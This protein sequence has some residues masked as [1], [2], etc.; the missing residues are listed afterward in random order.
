MAYGPLQRAFLL[1]G[2]ALRSLRQKSDLPKNTKAFVNDALRNK[3]E[4][5]ESGF[6]EALRGR[7]SSDRSKISYTDPGTGKVVSRSV[8]QIYSGSAKNSRQAELIF[9][10]VK[11]LQPSHCVELGTS[12]G[13]SAL[14][15]SLAT[16]GRISTF[17]GASE[18]AQLA[19]K[20][21]KSA[22]KSNIELH[23]G[24]FS[25]TLPKFLEQNKDID[26][27]FI[28]GNHYYEPT[29]K[30]FN[31]FLESGNEGVTML[32]DDINWSVEM[33][34]AWEEIKQDNRVKLSLDMFHMG[35][36]FTDSRFGE[37]H[38]SITA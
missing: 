15:M 13:L 19:K 7:L 2:H 22:L 33:R 16:K 12:L 5:I 24:M 28:D 36:I 31:K 20:H 30:Y 17:E 23:T 1:V 34:K 9:R 4:R 37:G 18:V 14:Y 6:V 25:D 35:L 32:F 10:L 29:M 26:F 3:N 27:A 11:Y 38:Y 8:K 21:F